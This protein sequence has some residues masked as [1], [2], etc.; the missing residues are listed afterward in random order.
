MKQRLDL[1]V[2]TL[3]RPST[4]AFDTRPRAVR[5]W[6]AELPI[7]H[8]DETAQRLWH[9]LGE[10]NRLAV[11]PANRFHLLEAFGPKAALVLDHLRR[12]YANQPLPLGAGAERAAAQAVDLLVEFLRG[13][14]TLLTQIAPKG[15]DIGRW[16]RFWYRRELRNAL[17]RFIHYGGA[18]LDVYRAIHQPP[19]AGLW[20]RVNRCYHLAEVYGFLKV[21]VPLPGDT[22][23]RTRIDETYRQVLLLSLLP[24]DVLTPAQSGEIAA[25][26]A[27]WVKLSIITT[28]PFTANKQVYAVRLTRDGGAIGTG[29]LD[30]QGLT[31]PNSRGLD[32][33]ALRTALEKR[34]A[35]GGRGRRW[36]REK[37]L[38]PETVQLLLDSWCSERQRSEQR[39]VLAG[40]AEVIIGLAALN[41]LLGDHHAPPQEDPSSPS[42]REIS[43]V[44]EPDDAG[45]LMG[46]RK[47][48]VDVWQS[49]YIDPQKIRPVTPPTRDWRQQ[50]KTVETYR[51]FTGRL[52]DSSDH[53]YC[54]RVDRG[55]VQHVA[56]GMLL[57]VR[58]S[59]QMPWQVGVIARLTAYG[60]EVELGARMVG[61]APV[62]VVLHTR[63]GR[64]VS[65]FPA[66]LA[67]DEKTRHLLI[68]P[69]VPAVREGELAVELGGHRV[70]VKRMGNGA[71][72]RH[73]SLFVVD[74]LRA[75]DAHYLE[76][77][78]E[79]PGTKVAPTA[80]QPATPPASEHEE[81]PSSRVEQLMAATGMSREDAEFFLTAEAAHDTDPCPRLKHGEH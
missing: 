58:S 76:V 77:Q 68:A 34:L 21:R 2:Q 28:P 37:T 57:A 9:A 38:S 73:V 48:D 22:K 44:P 47:K 16:R 69:A 75:D 24:T 53:G 59:E 51:S 36:R 31:S 32:V 23:H 72:S 10:T 45:Q 56:A 27:E 62:A 60:D 14:R 79:M 41:H 35:R 25:S 63:S 17:H 29:T 49:V 61:E 78:P 55:N 30:E 4:G 33:S 1:S 13:Y 12:R 5:R 42:K 20:K 65:S 26:L 64:G 19:P 50:A 7:A 54:V 18:L 43:L 6:V 15:K 66:V 39:E 46:A 81:P 80:T 11:S 40:Q 3:S 67:R 8:I 52:L 71:H 70:P 74:V